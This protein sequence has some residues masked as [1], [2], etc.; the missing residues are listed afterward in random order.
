M[1]WRK[2]N[3]K[4]CRLNFS[5]ALWWWRTFT[6]FTT[7]TTTTTSS[8]LPCNIGVN[9]VEGEARLAYCEAGTR[10]GKPEGGK[11]LIVGA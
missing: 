2:G 11:Q 6:A 9:S 1:S 7:A 4:W 10:I 5:L 3:D 8:V